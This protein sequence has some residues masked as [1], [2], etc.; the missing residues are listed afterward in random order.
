MDLLRA[1][2][3]EEFEKAVKGVGPSPLLFTWASADGQIGS[4]AAGRVPERP[5]PLAALL[6]MDGSTS[7]TNWF[8]VKVAGEAFQTRNPAAGF[9]VTANNGL[10]PDHPL[11]ATGF[12]TPRA[13]RITK[14]LSEAT[15][16]RTKLTTADM[17]S[18]QL[19]SVDEYV[20]ETLQDF[21]LIMSTAIKRHANATEVE[22]LNSLL[23][24]VAKWDADYRVDSVAASIYSAWEFEFRS[25]AADADPKVNLL[26]LGSP[27][28]TTFF[29][30]N[31]VRW[32]AK[33]KEDPNAK[34]DDYWCAA[35]VED[36]A[37]ARVLV[38]TWRR[39]DRLLKKSFKTD[40]VSS[41]YWGTL[42]PYVLPHQPFSQTP[43]RPF[44]ELRFPTAGN[45]RT[46]LATVYYHRLHSFDCVH[47]PT[48]RM[49]V[50]MD[51]SKPSYFVL[52]SGN[53][54]NLASSYYRAMH[55]LF[56][57][58]KYVK[59]RFEDPSNSK[60]FGPVSAKLKINFKKPS[61]RTE[62]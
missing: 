55:D 9:L 41:Y 14:L 32:G 11:G 53:S 8:G 61:E 51:Y 36:D 40:D 18:I 62:L 5:D 13:H 44:F 49:V 43:L 56:R 48:L 60:A 24:V 37:C 54:D 59:M 15:K 30:T 27:V 20:R 26:I 23:D 17:M 10:A 1:K 12:P 21:V 7:K 2:N 16:K 50:D 57:E 45:A 42:H 34:L 46:P 25:V 29:F 35:D 6:I 4:I 22:R 19:D 47:G 31:I 28:A 58:G 33:L 52:D 38:D 39:G 3:P